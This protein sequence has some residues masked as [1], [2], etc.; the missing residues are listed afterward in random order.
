[1]GAALV[2]VAAQS[3]SALPAPVA[4]LWVKAAGQTDTGVDVN[5]GLAITGSNANAGIQA[6]ACQTISH[7]VA[8]A[9][10][11]I[12]LWT[13]SGHTS[14]ADSAI[15]KVYKGTY[16]DTPGNVACTPSGS[17]TSAGIDITQSHITIEQWQSGAFND[18]NPK[19]KIAPCSTQA[20]TS[21]EDNTPQNV[22]INVAP[23]TSGT[24]LTKLGIS[25]TDAQNSFTAGSQDFVGVYFGDSSGTL[26]DVTVTGVTQPEGYFG[27]QP[28]TNGDIY[29]V[30]CVAGEPFVSSCPSNTP[31]TSTVKLTNV[32]LPGAGTV[33]WPPST[34]WPTETP[35]L[36]NANEY[37]SY[38]KAGIVCDGQNT[39]CKITGTTVT[40]LG[41]TNLNAQNGI[42]IAWGATASI[43]NSTVSG[44]SYGCN[45]V[46]NGSC[47]SATGILA[48]GD[49]GVTI[50]GGT[51]TSNDINIAPLFDGPSEGPDGDGGT[52]ISI[53]GVHIT[54]ASDANVGS[55]QGVETYGTV[56]A[57][58]GTTASPNTITGNDGGGVLDYASVGTT[59]TGNKIYGNSAS[60]SICTA[61][62]CPAPSEDGGGVLLEGSTDSDTTLNQFDASATS[63]SSD[64]N[65]T[66]NVNGGVIAEE[67]T[68]G[69]N[70]VDDNI[71]AGAAGSGIQLELSSG[72]TVTGNTICTYF[73][74]PGII[75][76][77]SDDNTIGVGADNGNTVTDSE[78]GLYVGGND[79]TGASTGNLIQDNNLSGELGGTLADGWASP[80][81][82]NMPGGP[83]QGVQGEVFFQS[84]QTINSGSPGAITSAC[85]DAAL[86]YDGQDCAEV[87][88]PSFVPAGSTYNPD[89]G[90]A[91]SAVAEY[92][93]ET[94]AANEGGICDTDSS[95]DAFGA[96][97]GG[98]PVQTNTNSPMPLFACTDG[99]GDVFVWGTTT[100]GI[101]TGSA[102]TAGQATGPSTTSE[103]GCMDPVPGA[104]TPGAGGYAACQGT[105]LTLAY[106]P[107]IDTVAGGTGTT[108]APT[109]NGY[110]G[111]GNENFFTNNT[112]ST[113]TLGLAA[114]DASGS[115]EATPFTST[116]SFVAD[117]NSSVSGIQNSWGTPGTDTC[118]PTT[119]APQCAP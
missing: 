6:D 64:P 46:E 21:V 63:C 119:A 44:N 48:Y 32:D 49:G 80:L 26:K 60:E 58:I 116:S 108:Q 2:G 68:G 78:I 51:V 113:G 61:L 118:D 29:A 41:E 28:G 77:G 43:T 35:P 76:V 11:Q 39:S 109:T 40:G 88:S 103:P 8:V 106:L 13:T 89:P 84:Q 99:L 52:P 96:P 62:G 101:T 117:T 33:T 85:T 9:D 15:I 17:E 34:T 36:S 72:F 59:I 110:G 65:D 112:W 14:G 55:G 50:S 98:V 97:Y 4:H 70:I 10:A 37:G 30:T 94:G 3:A 92:L 82:W 22:L 56:G 74:G 18:L 71:F 47:Y 81:S 25:G 111:S 5:C 67:S 86:A 38:D 42:Q 107:A 75:I 24:K 102:S 19:V 105:V 31:G 93:L 20:E 114:L 69:T 83:N 53:T 95:S 12:N 73:E 100:V 104:G 7:A 115:N 54:N 27:D 79:L 1:M 66:A 87:L 45:G 16:Y 91:F 90:Q 23:G 57:V